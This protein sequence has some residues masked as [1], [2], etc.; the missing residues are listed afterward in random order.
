MIKLGPT[1]YLTS[2]VTGVQRGRLSPR[3][4]ICGEATSRLAMRRLYRLYSSL[5]R[6][7]WACEVSTML[8]EETFPTYME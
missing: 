5:N 7:R 3:L 8:W 1:G 4:G 2:P 6:A